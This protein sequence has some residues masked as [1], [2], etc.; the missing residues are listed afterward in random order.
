MD[1]VTALRDMKLHFPFKESTIAYVPDPKIE[2]FTELVQQYKGDP[3]IIHVSIEK[4][5][6]NVNQNL[7]KAKKKRF[8]L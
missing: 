2:E 3:L 1:N 4:F 7:K 6:C 5:S 8:V